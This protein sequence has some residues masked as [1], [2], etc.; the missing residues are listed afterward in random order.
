VLALLADENFKDQ[1]VTGLRRQLRNLDV[2][3][4]RTAALL[5]KT[6]PQVLE[7]AAE[8]DRVLLTHDTRTMKGFAYERVEQGLPMAGVVEV[9]NLLPIGRAI[10]DLVLIATSSS[11]TRSGTA[12]SACPSDLSPSSSAST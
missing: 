8:E 2:T 9:P 12:S 5:G 10:E 11:P 7:R 6:D 3:T 4:A 1:T